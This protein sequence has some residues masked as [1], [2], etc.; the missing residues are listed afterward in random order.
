MPKLPEKRKKYSLVFATI[1][2]FCSVC[3][4]GVSTFAWFQANAQVSIRATNS[5]T[6]ITVAQPDTFDLG[7]ATLYAYT[8]NGSYGYTGSASG[9]ISDDENLVNFRKLT[10]SGDKTA[11]LSVS[12]LLPGH[13]MSFG[14]KIASDDG[15]SI[16][17]GSLSITGYTTTNNNDR[18]VLSSVTDGST[19][20]LD[21]YADSSQKIIRIE[22]VV[23]FYGV[24]NA[25]G[26]FALGSASTL[27]DYD[28]T[29]TS[30]SGYQSKSYSRVDY[31]IATGS[32]L[33]S[34]TIYL[35]YTI[36]FSN[37][38]TT[39]YQEYTKTDNNYNK[40]YSVIANDSASARYFHQEGTGNSSCYEGLS[41]TIDDLY[42]E[43]L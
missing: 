25:T 26:A 21:T 43:A 2:A 28:K 13:K 4:A 19:G 11:Y 16:S 27:G 5:S 22:D 37:A 34:S 20:T 3:T 40:C 24:V 32:E 8:E 39:W 17:D 9:D 38:D 35:F 30:G 31:E 18:K 1:V 36:E 12:G 14:I 42:V 15:S 33:S 41:F 6:T 23:K 29:Y 10:T 7:A